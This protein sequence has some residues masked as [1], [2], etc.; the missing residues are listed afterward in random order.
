MSFIKKLKLHNYKRFKELEL[1]LDKE[2]NVLI[3]DNESGKTT[4][5]EAINLTISGKKKKIDSLY[6]ESIFNY[7]VINQFL[8][9]DRKY[10][11]LP[12][13]FVELYFNEQN[14]PNLFGQNNSEK[15]TS[16]LS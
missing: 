12:K 10:D 7:E 2:L 8:Q 14:E 1:E 15:M 16:A 6:L 9:S 5:L 11:N 3:G 4:I 13:L